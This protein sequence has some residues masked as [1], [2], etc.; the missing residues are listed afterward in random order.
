MAKVIAYD[1]R[2][3]AEVLESEDR[4]FF[5]KYL[6]DRTLAV[7]GFGPPATPMM[8]P[9][10]FPLSSK[11][12]GSKLSSTFAAPAAVEE[13]TIP[14]GVPDDQ[15]CA[16]LFVMCCLMESRAGQRAMLQAGLLPVLLRSCY[17]VEAN[18]VQWS[19]L[20][21]YRLLDQH[22][23]AMTAALSFTGEFMVGCLSWRRMYHCVVVCLQINLQA[24][25]TW[26]LGVTYQQHSL[27]LNP[28]LSLRG[29][30]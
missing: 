23:E 26:G 5:V 29:N 30:G 15:R 22:E 8:T 6:A 1:S 21:L 18:V 13:D 11:L 27:A 19:C 2:C 16:A 17:D 3:Q 7:P 28:T 9:A 24:Q 10:P 20:C 14:V 4:V 12:S 25:R